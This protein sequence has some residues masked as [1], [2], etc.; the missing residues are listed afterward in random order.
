MSNTALVD[1]ALEQLCIGE[2]ALASRLFS[3]ALAEEPASDAAQQ[4]LKEAR[5]GV[6]AAQPSPAQPQRA[7]E[8]LAQR[9]LY[10]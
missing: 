8:R 5:K 10:C 6:S 4:G 3:E 9:G 2:Y 1:S 7:S